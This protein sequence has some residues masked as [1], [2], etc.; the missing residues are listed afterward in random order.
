[1]TEIARLE[2]RGAIAI[3]T[4]DR[5]ERRNALSQELWRALDARL[6]EIEADLP[7]ALILTG[8]GSA[9]CAGMDLSPDNP[10]VGTFMQALQDQDSSIARGMLEELR[11]IVDRLAGLPIPTI[12]AINGVAYGGGAEIAARCTFRVVDPDATVC[13]SEVKLGLMPD[14]G[15]GV[16][17]TRLLGPGHAAD[18]ILTARK[19]KGEEAGRIGFANRVSTPGAVLDAA[20]ELAHAIAENGPR[21]VRSSLAVIQASVELPEEQ[22]LELEI[23]T[24]AEL[25]AGGECTHGVTAFFERKAPEFPD[26]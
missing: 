24:A 26:P 11:A 5:P 1:M 18:L 4:L 22:A 14:L 7:R 3:L 17:L 8:T 9:F 23:Q 6:T 2:R 16:A 20:L 12:A 19:F 25:I 15:G 21:A 13:F 10:Q